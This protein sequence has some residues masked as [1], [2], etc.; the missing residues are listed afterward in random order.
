MTKAAAG[1]ARA[2]ERLR[3][4]ELTSSLT[5]QT[6]TIGLVPE[7]KRPGRPD[8]AGEPAPSGRSG[9]R[10]ERQQAQPIVR[11]PDLS[12]EARGPTSPRPAEK[13]AASAHRVGPSP[14]PRQ[15]PRSGGHSVRRTHAAPN[16][17]RGTRLTAQARP[18]TRR[19]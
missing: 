5:D 7:R 19:G 14:R 3:F 9:A 13:A 11:T 1:A 10:T 12:E 16:A 17:R 2:I 15:A 18:L 6:S 4:I 8:A